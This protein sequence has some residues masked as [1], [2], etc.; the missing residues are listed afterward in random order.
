MVLETLF[1]PQPMP[2]LGQVIIHLKI[3][4]EGNVFEDLEFSLPSY[5]T[6]EDIKRE[7]YAHGPDASRL[8]RFVFMGVKKGEQFLK[9]ID[10]NFFDDNDNIIYMQ[11]PTKTVLVRPDNRWITSDGEPLEFEYNQ[12][13][14]ILIEDFFEDEINKAH[15]EGVDEPVITIY[16]YELARLVRAF[17]GVRPI[18]GRDWYSRFAP[19]FPGVPPNGQPNEDDVKETQYIM[20]MA[21][22]RT[23]MVNKLN[24][25][26]SY[27]FP[28]HPISLRGAMRMK[29]VWTPVDD[30]K[31]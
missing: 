3:W 11:Y 23:E 27:E 24:E 1:R 2:A 30:F 20:T 29:F 12:T 17:K 26:L 5:Y 16:V 6:T 9:A 19:F 31:G 15:E 28:V 7:Y 8:P 21:T 25:I 18:S 13:N 4:K 10:Y 22:K 14:N